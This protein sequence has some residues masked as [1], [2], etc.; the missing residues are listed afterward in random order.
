LAL[1]SP[2]IGSFTVGD[3][4][5]QTAF[6][7]LKFLIGT[8]TH[9]GWARLHV[10]GGAL[11]FTTTLFDYAYCDQPNTAID[12]GQTSGACGATVAV[13]EPASL[14][15]LTAGAVAI[16]ALRRWRL[17]KDSASSLR[18]TARS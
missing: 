16:A 17:G 14:L 18:L 13:A 3:W 4:N 5:E 10:T 12:T 7:G 11:G 9:F 15:L 1:A 2:S 6:A 8:D